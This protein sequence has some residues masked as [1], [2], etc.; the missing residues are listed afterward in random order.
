MNSNWFDANRIL[1]DEKTH[2]HKDSSFYSL[3]DFIDGKSSQ[4]TSE[5]E[6]LG[7][8]KGKSL[9]HLQCH[10]GMDTMSWER[11]GAI[12]T[13]VDL[14]PE[15]I[16]LANETRETLGSS[17]R[18]INCN[19]YDLEQHLDEEFDIVFTSYGTY[20]WLPDL[21]EWARLIM[22]YLKPGGTFYLA[23]FHPIVWMY[24]DDFTFHKYPYHRDEPFE[25]E[26]SG[27]Y[28]DREADIGGKAYYWNHGFGVLFG[29]LL[30]A[31]LII[32]DF[33]EYNYS[34]YPCFNNVV[35]VAKGQWKIKGKEDLFPMV[36]EL[37]A[38]RG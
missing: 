17:A 7:D 8:D 34:P 14:S 9:L 11:E 24:D 27:T 15:A 26:I 1:W 37:R 10:S 36:F 3:K 22:R 16:K 18:F 4:N 2:V 5:L 6:G 28:T 21:K 38:S 33:K 31:G 12:V 35:E 32:Q 13:G 29:A 20:G 19:V 25:E 23:D 30:E